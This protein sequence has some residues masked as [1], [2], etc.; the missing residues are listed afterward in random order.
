MH[1]HNNKNIDNRPDSIEESSGFQKYVKRNFPDNA[2]DILNDPPRRRFLKTMAASLC[3]SGFTSCG[4]P[5]EGDKIISNPNQPHSAFSGLK[6]QFITAMELGGSANGLM[7]DIYNGRPIKIEGAPDH[8]SSL[9]AASLIAQAS[10]LDLY[11]PHRDYK[12]IQKIDG[13]NIERSWE[14]TQAF[15]KKHFSKLKERQ[16]EGFYI[17]SETTSSLI[18]K[19]M[20][21]RLNKAFPEVKWFEYES[22]SQ[23]NQRDGARLSFSTPV[24]SYAHLDKA[25]VILALDS[26]AFDSN[27]DALRLSQ[28]FSQGRNAGSESMNRIYAV[29]PRM[30]SIGAIADHRLPLAA[31]HIQHF[32]LALIAELFYKQNVKPNMFFLNLV[33]PV[34]RFL[35]HPFDKKWLSALAADIAK[36]PGKSAV[37]TGAAQPPIVH[38]LTDV[39]NGIMKNDKTVTYSLDLEPERPSY[40]ES[41][42]ELSGDIESG[43]V[44]TLVILGGNP[45]YDA[46]VDLDFGALLEKIPTSIHLSLYR[47]E[48][49]IL[50]K[51]FLPR[52][53]YLEAWDALR[54]YDGTYTMAQPLIEPLFNGKSASQL[55]AYIIEDE[56]TSDRDIFRRALNKIFNFGSFE[57]NLTK[58]LH[59]G[60]IPNTRYDLFGPWFNNLEIQLA[61]EKIPDEMPQLHENNLEIIFYPDSKIHDG[62]FAN[63]SW[64]QELP[65]SLSIISWDNTALISLQTAQK[66]NIQTGDIIILEYKGRSL[67]TPACIMPGQANNSIA[68]AMGYGHTAPGLLSNGVGFNANVL[69]TKDA[70]NFDAGLSIKKTGRKY[71]F[72][73]SQDHF[74]FG[75]EDQNKQN[76]QSFKPIRGTVLEKYLS[77]PTI[78]GKNDQAEKQFNP[79]TTNCQWGMVIDLN[80]CIGCNACIVACQ[81]E[82]N[83][84]AVG[85]EEIIQNHQMHW[86]RIN[87]YFYGDIQSPG[88]IYQPVACVHCQEAPCEETCPTHAVTHN[89]EGVT[90]VVYN[91]CEGKQECSRKCPYHVLHFNHRDNHAEIKNVEKML[92]NPEVT[93]RSKGIMEK[94]TYCIQRIE[95]A[96]IDARNIGQKIEDGAIVPACAQTCPTNA[97]V[98][99]DINNP[100]SQVSKLR[101]NN[102]AYT[103]LDELKTKPRTQYLAHLRN[104]NPEIG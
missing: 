87:R 89:A 37:I 25:H 47:N 10:L 38:T 88:V 62:R 55:L 13:Q 65:D 64:L 39:I 14:E 95:Q 19:D 70:L 68:L 40:T 15:I 90:Q 41:I 57:A 32:L 61:I 91:K 26:D 29:E 7:V 56:I 94:C 79:K 22:V 8:P 80:S 11:D 103:L 77:D 78:F 101:Q 86:L 35:N 27:P 63:N 75:T 53:H 2:E 51:W 72:A 34:K 67:I 31:C 76:T 21:Q 17:L 23:D 96:K 73:V 104:P 74:T 81:A 9:G 58:W 33:E 83:I 50:S 66:L 30:T 59:D 16:G 60:I 98:F 102:R 45:A 93:V 6:K 18:V 4:Q 69:R 20:R 3:L 84:P 12:P 54:A 46:P 28:G 52:S 71:L 24:R 36:N 100:D 97:I 48:T 82:N 42:S 1:S 99:G 49:S 5:P 92:F 43:K 85:R 44:D